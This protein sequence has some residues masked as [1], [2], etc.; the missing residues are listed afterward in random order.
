MPFPDATLN[1]MSRNK[2]SKRKA[3]ELSRDRIA[4]DVAAYLAAGGVIAEA[5]AI[6]TKQR[7]QK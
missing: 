7:W 5:E 4:E 6:E 3:N 1:N 2:P